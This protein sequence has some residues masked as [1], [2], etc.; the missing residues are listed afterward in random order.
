MTSRTTEPINKCRF[1]KKPHS[2][3]ICGATDCGK[4]EFTLNLLETKYKDFFKYI[5]IVCPTWRYNQ[6]YLKRTWLFNDPKHVF[7]VNPKKKIVPK[8]KDPLN[9]TL[10]VVFFFF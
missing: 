9:D 3:I 7:L 5:I 1:I 8:S 4:T 2:A 10:K 6:T